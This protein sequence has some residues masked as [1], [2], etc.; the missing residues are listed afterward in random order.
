MRMKKRFLIYA[1]LGLLLA[2]CRQPE[3]EYVDFE[4]FT[5]T[6]ITVSKIFMEDG[7]LNPEIRMFDD[8]NILRDQ[9]DPA[10]RKIASTSVADLFR[11]LMGVNTTNTLVQI[12]GTYKGHDIDGSTLVQSGKIIMP[13]TGKI[14]NIIIVSHYTI[15]ANYECPSETF[16]V[17]AML[18]G[19]GYAMIFA[20]YIG[21]GVTQDRIHPYL[22]AQS[23]AGSVVDM[24]LASMAYIKAQGREIEDEEVILLG[25]S[26]GGA[27]TLGVMNLIQKKYSDKI[28]IKRV[29]AGAGPYDLT[30][31]YDVSM[32]EDKTGIPCAIPMI[33]QGISEG[34]KLNL[35][36]EDFFQPKLL[37]HYNSWINSKQ[38]TVHEINQL[39]DVTRLSDI[40][41]PEGCNKQSTQTARLYRALMRNSVLRFTPHAP[42]YLFHSRED[43]TVPFV[44][45]EKAEQ[46]FKGKD[47]EYNFGYYGDHMSG[48]LKFIGAVGKELDQNNKK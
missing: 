43:D 48:F 44:N 33:V 39:I 21:F 28:Q 29:Y 42:L 37:E 1:F 19:K 32:S 45:S 9:S 34:E 13:K 38:F 5:P 46:A 24:A 27:T 2:G 4:T 16:P 7:S 35:K 8:G 10:K 41:T 40:M 31:T 12:A 23:T 15:G 30:A 11:D 26:Q 3:I 36:M 22:H 17:E 14:R 47:V 25:Y 6:S 18:A 20:D